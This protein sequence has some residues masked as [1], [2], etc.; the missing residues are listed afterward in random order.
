MIWYRIKIVSGEMNNGLKLIPK[1]TLEHVQPSIFY[2]ESSFSETAE[3]CIFM[4]MFFDFLNVRNQ[5]KGN[6][7]RKEYLKCYREID[8]ARFI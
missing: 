3:F 2:H 6:T 1:F 8:E 4:D 5:Y 7:K